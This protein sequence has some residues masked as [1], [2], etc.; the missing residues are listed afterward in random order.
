MNVGDIL[1]LSGFLGF[2]L[3]LFFY[4]I[5]LS[6][7]L[8]NWM[9]INI[10]NIHKN[11]VVRIGLCLFLIMA[12]KMQIEVA[13]ENQETNVWG[14]IQHVYQTMIPIP[15]MLVLFLFIFNIM[16]LGRCDIS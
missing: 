6:A 12:L 2:C 5:L 1:F 16:Q 9:V 7:R 8:G 3:F 4:P 13:M 14:I 15:F 10:V 11:N